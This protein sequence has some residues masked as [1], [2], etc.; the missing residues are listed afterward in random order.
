MY[1]Y[2][3]DQVTSPPSHQS[4]KWDQTASFR[5]LICDGV[6]RH[7]VDVLYKS[8]RLEKTI[9]S[10]YEGSRAPLLE[11]RRETSPPPHQVTSPPLYDRL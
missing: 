2:V 7:P 5:L 3:Y 8:R 10:S 9:C 6:R 11:R 4:S 1:E